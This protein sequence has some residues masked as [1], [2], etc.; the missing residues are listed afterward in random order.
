MTVTF[1]PL[2]LGEVLGLGRSIVRDFHPYELRG[3]RYARREVLG[4][5][6][7]ALAVEAGG[8]YAG[9][10][11]HGKPDRHGLLRIA[12]LATE[13]R[14]RGQHIGEQA[15]TLMRRRYPHSAIYFE[16]EDPDFAQSPE[17]LSIRNRRIEFYRRNGFALTGVCA[18]VLQDHYRIIAAG[19]SDGEAAYREM[20]K[21]YFDMAGEDFFRRHITVFSPASQKSMERDKN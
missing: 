19:T 10:L 1:R 16:V 7:V 6:A 20:A 2:A 17:D 11:I 21:L 12:Y 4:G 15:L 8:A 9:Y 5:K 3:Y 13:P 14:F 18:Q